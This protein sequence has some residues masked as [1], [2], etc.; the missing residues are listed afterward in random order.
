M[1]L[2]RRLVGWWHARRHDAALLEELEDHRAHIQA[3]FEADGL[4]PREAAAASRRAM[5]NLTLAREDAREVWIARWADRLGRDLRFG[6]RGL[7]REPTFAL[8]AIATFAL[9]VATTTTVFSVVDAELWRALPYPQPRQLVAVVSRAPGDRRASDMLSGADLVEW[10]ATAPGLVELAGVG[11]TGR[12]VLRL[13]TAESVLV[14]EV[15]P[16]YFSTLGRAAVA[17]RTFTPGAARGLRAVVFTDRAWR[18]LFGPDLSSAGREVASVKLDEETVAVMGVVRAD[19]SLGADP[20]VFLAIDEGAASFLDR[21]RRDFFC[22]IA[23]LASGADPAVVRA[24]IQAVA[25]RLT[26]SSPDDRRGHVIEFEDLAVFFTGSNWRSL[27]FFLGASLI[28]LMLGT[29]NVATLLLGRAFRRTREFALRAAL[30]GGRAALAR[31]LLVEGALVALPGGVIGMLVTSWALGLL[32]TSLP[33]ETLLRGADIPVDVRVAVFAFGVT[34]V[35]TAVFALMPLMVAGRVALSGIIGR[36]GR[37]GRPVTEARGRA[38]LLTAQMALT[39]LLIAGAGLF[40]KSYARLVR[41]PLG[42]EPAGVL[43]VRA[44]LSGP[45]YDVDAQVRAYAD[46]LLDAARASPGVRD[47]SVASS[48][49][50]GSGPP[51]TFVVV[52][53][54]RPAAGSEPRAILR[55]VT[56]DYFQTMGITIV[57]GR[58]FTAAD[59][60]GAPRVT[61]VNETLARRMFEG[62]EPIGRVIEL[63]PAVRAPWTRRPGQVLVVGVVANIKEVGLNEVEFAGIHLPFAQAPAPS[64]E[65]LARVEGPAGAKADVIRRLAAHVDPDI[66][67]TRVTT[68][69][70]RVETALQRDRFT[71]LLIVAF[72]GVAVLLAGI[73]VYGGVAYAVEARRQEFGVRLALGATPRRLIVGALGRAGWLGA[74]GGLIGLCGTLAV[75]KVLGNALYLVPGSHNG[76]LFGVTTT[77]PL[78]LGGAVLGTIGLALAAGVVPALRVGRVDPVGA[79]RND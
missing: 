76:L 59:V 61:V 34:A 55:A 57:R 53:R 62:E 74:A 1:R 32:A 12:R 60:A 33:E 15:T 11:R 22:G 20:D 26:E 37:A 49:P 56:P 65:L 47:A 29:V 46:A 75:A 64:F 52:G 38:V 14:A 17:G 44:T 23:R 8:T 7:R 66:P 35:T 2:L 48:S 73:G 18:R 21:T 78:T 16:N 27:Y 39:V 5:G 10:R 58:A 31:Q 9:G 72:A 4:S 36:G 45:R 30:G 13:Q 69:E 77:D 28:V 63:L 3:D 67:V 70:Q 54:P 68:F 51:V 6:F 40:L 19:D 42:F 79:L 50:L 24:Q 43:A 25:T 41:V 71:T